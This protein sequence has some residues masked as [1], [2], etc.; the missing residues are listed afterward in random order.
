M[1]IWFY[2]G[3]MLKIAW[4]IVGSKLLVKKEAVYVRALFIPS[5]V[6]VSENLYWLNIQ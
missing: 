3:G 2:N 1:H 5:T 6:F 4:R